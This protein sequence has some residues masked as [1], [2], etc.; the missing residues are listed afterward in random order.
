[1]SKPETKLEDLPREIP[2][3]EGKEVQE[4]F[5]YEIKLEKEL[6]D[7]TKKAWDAIRDHLDCIAMVDENW[8]NGE[9]VHKEFDVCIDVMIENITGSFERWCIENKIE[10]PQF[11]EKCGDQ[12]DKDPNKKLCITCW[13]NEKYIEYRKM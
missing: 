7:I 1:M 13:R 4:V 3:I 2:N 11:C 5:S 10:V 9:S 12:I 6:E 8:Q